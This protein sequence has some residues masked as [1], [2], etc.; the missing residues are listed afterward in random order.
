VLEDEVNKTNKTKTNYS[1]Q[2]TETLILVVILA[3]KIWKKTL[4]IGIL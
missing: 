3:M 4:K 2:F 1:L